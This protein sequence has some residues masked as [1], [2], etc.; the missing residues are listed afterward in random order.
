MA[1]GDTDWLERGHGSGEG[2]HPM[3]KGTT[4]R[5]AQRVSIRSVL[6]GSDVP[7][8]PRNA[9]ARRRT[10]VLVGW[11]LY[12]LTAVGGTAAAFTV[13]DTLFPALGSP[14][15]RPLWISVTPTVPAT[16]A[17]STS[18]ARNSTSL[19]SDTVPTTVTSIDE[20]IA[21]GATVPD[22]ATSSTA[23]DEGNDNTPQTGTTVANPRSPGST[24]V[25]TIDDNPGGTSTPSSPT[26]SSSPDT[27]DGGHQKGKGGGGGGGGSDPSAP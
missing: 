20:Q 18:A 23:D 2:L 17:A 24:T 12:C 4:G 9:R 22:D 16:D 7:P 19:V 6:R 14:A 21:A 13:R 11:L 27:T 25:T 26:Q 10:K 15:T 5:V 8:K 3:I 1:V